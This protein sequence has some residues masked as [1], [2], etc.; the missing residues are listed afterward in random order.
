ME[1]LRWKAGAFVRSFVN[2]SFLALR[3][4]LPGEADLNGFG[5]LRPR[6]VPSMGEPRPDVVVGDLGYGESA[7]AT[8]MRPWSSTKMCSGTRRIHVGRVERN[9]AATSA[10]TGYGSSPSA[11]I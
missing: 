1:D 10:A 11:V 7:A 2:D 9:R 5:E 6:L 3:Q 4:R 8:D